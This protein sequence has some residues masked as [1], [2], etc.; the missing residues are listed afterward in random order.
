MAQ[1]IPV[2]TKLGKVSVAECEMMT[3]PRDTSA[4]VV[5]LWENHDVH[6]DYSLTTNC[7]M[8]KQTHIER[9]KVLKDEG[10]D[11][12]DGYLLASTDYNL[13][14][15]VSRIQVTTYN[16]EKG[17]VVAT[18]M[19]KSDIVRSEYA[20]KVVKIAYAAPNVKVGSVVEVSYEFE[21][22][23]YMTIPD[24][25]FQRA[26]PVNLCEY[27]VAIPKWLTVRKNSRGY[28]HVD[29]ESSVEY[30]VDLGSI[31]PGNS[32]DVDSYRAVDLP[33]LKSEPN[34]FC[35]R[36]FRTAV[37]Y[38]AIAVTLPGV[39]HQD[40]SR[41]WGNIAEA[42]TDSEIYKR[43][44]AAC[45]FK[46]DIDAIKSEGADRVAD[47]I[48]LIQ[49]KVQWNK[50]I[51]LIPDKAADILK[52]HSGTSSDINAL[53]GSAFKYAGYD[54]VPVLI[55][56]RTDGTLMRHRPSL[57]SFSTFILKIA[58][59][60]GS[61]YFVD[62]SDP[63][64]YINVMNDDFLID[65]GFAV[66]HDK[67]FEWVDITGLCKSSCAY[68]VSAVIN[69][70]GSL[71]GTFSC[72]NSN[73]SSLDFK[74]DY[75]SYDKEESF[76]EEVEQSMDIEIEDFQTGGIQDYSKS[77]SMKFN[78]TKAAGE[79]T[80]DVIF[81]NPFLLKFHSESLFREEERKL[82]ID[83]SYPET[84]SYTA[85]FEIP[86][87]YVVDQLPNSVKYVSDIP[88]VLQMRCG[89]D[90]RTVMLTYTCTNK[91]L[92]VLPEQYKDFRQFWADIC[93][94]YKQMIVLKK[95]Q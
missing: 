33:A 22:A 94:V 87:G 5:V 4:A 69:P 53:A 28:E 12:A 1:S 75:R 45:R 46:E 72:S 37:E 52:T 15:H 43:M 67:S 9:V 93:A 79:S 51:D 31:L 6:I 59:K 39:L 23:R 29:Y 49:S 80:P 41:T 92:I 54:V 65:S 95:A 34:V 48:R 91:A 71:A 32:L 17:K 21:T 19:P 16:L 27:R 7:I 3:Y 25:Y 26:E 90:G 78:F 88:S 58:D 2:E 64:G 11:Y 44:N 62:A 38:D 56:R 13:A 14:E 8:M 85:R 42:V 68:L 47:I 63:S 74:D 83:F 50:E 86:E 76:I 57:R 66:S 18:K 10:K 89:F 24:F 84:I 20:D 70:D 55:R 81:V 30:G 36:Q 35:T 60:D 40:F 77:S 61:V 82:P 73:I